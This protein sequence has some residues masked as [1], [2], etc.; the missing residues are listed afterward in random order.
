MTNSKVFHCAPVS[1]L[2]CEDIA[3]QSCAMVHR[4]RI[5][6]EILFA[7]FP[8]SR[9]QHVSDLHSKFA[10]KLHHV[11]KYGRHSICGR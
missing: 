10:L 2:S 3:H 7:V 1:Y 4:W 8:A 6:R 11:W 9:V 5:F